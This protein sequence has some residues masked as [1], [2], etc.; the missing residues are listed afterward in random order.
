MRQDEEG[1]SDLG[2]E[3]AA[4]AAAVTAAAA[5]FSCGWIQPSHT[6]VDNY[7]R[8]QDLGNL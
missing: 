7:P 3:A 2:E 5:G 6:D 4:A 8:Q 1:R